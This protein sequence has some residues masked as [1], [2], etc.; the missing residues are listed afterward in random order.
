MFKST[1]S[2]FRAAK[3]TQSHAHVADFLW[4]ARAEANIPPCIVRLLSDTRLRLVIIYCLLFSATRAYRH[5]FKQY[6]QYKF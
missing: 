1:L 3:V 6:F 5:E 4:N 2:V